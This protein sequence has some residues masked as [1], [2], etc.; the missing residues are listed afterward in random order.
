[1][2]TSCESDFTAWLN[3]LR[4]LIGLGTETAETLQLAKELAEISLDLKL[5]EK[6]VSTSTITRMNLPSPRTPRQITDFSFCTNNDIS[7]SHEHWKI[8]DIIDNCVPIDY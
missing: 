8:C 4:T 2:I 5:W 7:M 3:G 6:D 1:L